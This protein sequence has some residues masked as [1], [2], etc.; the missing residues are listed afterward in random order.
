MDSQTIAVIPG[1]T[2]AIASDAET[3]PTIQNA[4]KYQKPYVEDDE[5]EGEQYQIAAQK[6][7]DLFQ[8]EE[9]DKSEQRSRRIVIR[10]LHIDTDVSDVLK[11]IVGGN[12]VSIKMSRFQDEGVAIVQFETARMAE[13]YAEVCANE[14]VQPRFQMISPTGG[15]R[16][17]RVEYYPLVP[18]QFGAAP[19]E[20][21]RDINMD[22]DAEQVT[23]CL[24]LRNMSVADLEDFWSDLRLLHD[25]S[26]QNFRSQI[27]SVH[28]DNYVW[29][30]NG[31]LVSGD[32][33]IFTTSMSMA[34]DLKGRV[35][36]QPKWAGLEYEHDPCNN[37]YAVLEQP[38]ED[39]PGYRFQLADDAEYT[40]INFLFINDQDWLE[41][42]VTSW[43]V[44]Q[45]SVWAQSRAYSHYM[46]TQQHLEGNFDR[47]D[48][49][50]PLWWAHEAMAHLE[51]TVGN[52]QHTVERLEVDLYLARRG[53]I[54]FAEDVANGVING[55][56]PQGAPLNL[57]VQSAAFLSLA[58]PTPNTSS[59]TPSSSSNSLTTIDPSSSSFLT[60]HTIG[61]EAPTMPCK[62]TTDD[63]S[64]TGDTPDHISSSPPTKAANNDHQVSLDAQDSDD[65]VQKTF[66]TVSLAEFMAMDDAQFS[67]F[68]TAFYVPPEGY[69][70]ARQIIVE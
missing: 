30:F 43:H 14:W 23:R 66:W 31:V 54:T 45:E 27:E 10:N 35:T 11:R 60:D 57:Q 19:E 13:L 12:V 63:E 41:Q 20:A 49:Y 26:T 55:P 51:D 59:V 18:R 5:D 1:A 50:I 7:A 25:L 33:H 21:V 47:D 28:L 3:S 4:I 67:S 62:A 15:F 8:T 65:D 32:L 39:H 16:Q 34:T 48:P 69:C 40:H 70:S 38:F 44:L 6:N 17:A 24:V 9:K 29:D 61:T 22:E 58:P 36:G 64:T 42:V 2:M 46:V 56:L 53:Y 37:P 52:L 68:G